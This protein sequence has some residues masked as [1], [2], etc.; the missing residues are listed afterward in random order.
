MTREKVIVRVGLSGIIANLVLV[1]FKAVIGVL[2]HSI[3][4]ISDAINNL[5]DALSSIITIIGTKLAKRK[6]DK[7]HPYGH[8]RI[9]YIT[10]IIIAALIF[11]AGATA[12]VESVN[13][14]IDSFK[15]NPTFPEYSYWMVIIVSAAIL[16]KIG[17]GLVFKF[18]GKK[19][20]SQALKASGT[21]ALFD[22][23][24]STATLVAAILAL[25][26]NIYIEGYLG[27]VIGLFII[28]SGIDVLKEA[29]SS[30]IGERIDDD[31]ARDIKKT[32]CEVPGVKGAYDLL[33]N[34]YG[35]D[36]FTGS[37]HIEVDGSLS[38]VD[39]QK[40]SMSVQGI[41]YQKF[42]IG[43][44]V[45]IYANNEDDKEALAIKQNILSMTREYPTIIQMHGFYLD[46]NI[47]MI[48]FDIVISFDE[49]DEK[50]LVEA[51]TK[52]VKES[53]PEYMPYI[54]ID[55]DVSAI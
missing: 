43:L 31:F 5:T 18:F 55:H 15:E 3:S 37:V 4:I 13:F 44:T 27:I 38:A 33:L 35:P 10:P 52:K 40:I 24:L 51:L 39:I 7:K 46:K 1:G 22:A 41:I 53:Y 25:T 16:V 50:A 9:E 21:D 26:V 14:I 8:G 30:I 11:V 42:N 54:A 20:N 48:K 34:N 32:I 17:L 6:S 2:A 19:V 47:K 36:N 12:I 49:K 45:G 29:F 23:I 28:K